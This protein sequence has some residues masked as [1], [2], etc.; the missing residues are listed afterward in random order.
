VLNIYVLAIRKCTFLGPYVRGRRACAEDRP[1][2]NLWELVT[3]GRVAENDD[4]NDD[5]TKGEATEFSF[6]FCTGTGR[7]SAPEPPHA[8]MPLTSLL[9]A[10]GFLS[11]RKPAGLVWIL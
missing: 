10:A 3:G 7:D 2:Q 9:R 1:T 6:L 8:N 4:G 11:D 5:K